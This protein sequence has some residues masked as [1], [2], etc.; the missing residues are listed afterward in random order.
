MARGGKRA[1]VNDKTTG[2]KVAKIDTQM[3][4][5]L[6]LETAKRK[7]QEALKKLDEEVA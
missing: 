2:N 4:A 6:A 1:A 7:R 5:E 3:K